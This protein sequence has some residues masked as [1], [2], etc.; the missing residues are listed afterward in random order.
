MQE[1]Y[2][3]QP[4]SRVPTGVAA[5][6]DPTRQWQPDEFS[7]SLHHL[8]PPPTPHSLHDGY[9]HLLLI[10]GPDAVR[11]AM[12]SSSSGH[13][14]FGFEWLLSLGDS[15]PR[16]ASQ[17]KGRDD[18]SSETVFRLHILGKRNWDKSQIDEARVEQ[19]VRKAFDVNPDTEIIIRSLTDH[20]MRDSTVATLS[21]SR[22]P[23]KIAKTS[24]PLQ[25]FCE[26]VEGLSLILDT[27]FYGFT[28]LHSRES[29][30]Y[31]FW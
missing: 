8:S 19:L 31:S 6:A 23:P 15:Q 18:L 27:H 21:F 9:A 29:S 17:L 10:L 7:V 2:V 12:A 30:E 22:I 26:T 24:P 1:T 11:I 25:E 13:G 5:S 16:A 20:H 3:E 28:P 4:H 14:Y